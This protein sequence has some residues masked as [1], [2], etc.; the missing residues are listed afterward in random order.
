MLSLEQFIES[1]GKAAMR[2]AKNDEVFNECLVLKFSEFMDA[3][4]PAIGTP[5]GYV[6]MRLRFAVLKYTYRQ[7]KWRFDPL[8]DD[9]A[10]PVTEAI[11]DM[12]PALQASIEK[13]EPDLEEVISLWA[14]GYTQGQIS[15]KLGIGI[16]KVRARINTAI[17]RLREDL[18][19]ALRSQET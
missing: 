13:L 17:I 18:T 11:A 7:A 3:Y 6:L 2:I 14:H 16:P 8:P 12:V 10:P 9:P 5:E 1:H 15:S 19:H 4:D